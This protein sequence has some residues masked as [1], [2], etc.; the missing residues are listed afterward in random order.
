[1]S[2]ILILNDRIVE[3]ILIK[4]LKKKRNKKKIGLKSA[5]KKTQ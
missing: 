5:R 1:M 2:S 3:K 4:N